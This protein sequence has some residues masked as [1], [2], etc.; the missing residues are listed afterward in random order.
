MGSSS[1]LD[2]FLKVEPTDFAGG[3]EV[4]KSKGERT[5]EQFCGFEHAQQNTLEVPSAKTWE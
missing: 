4:D 3:F 5:Q 2:V 1:I